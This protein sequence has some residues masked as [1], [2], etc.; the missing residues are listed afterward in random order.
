MDI[1]IR[2]ADLGGVRARVPRLRG[3]GDDHTAPPPQFTL[4]RTPSRRGL[5]GTIFFFPTKAV[6][7]CASPT[8]LDPTP[9]A[10]PVGRPKA[11]PLGSPNPPCQPCVS[12]LIDYQIQ[13]FIAPPFSL[14]SPPSCPGGL[15][16]PGLGLPSPPRGGLILL[17]A[18]S[19]GPAPGRRCEP[20]SAVDLPKWSPR[21]S[22]ALSLMFTVVFWS[23]RSVKRRSRR[24]SGHRGP[25][26]VARSS[27]DVP[28][29]FQ[30]RSPR[31]ARRLSGFSALR[32]PRGVFQAITRGSQ[33]FSGHCGHGGVPLATA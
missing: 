20:R 5:P 15:D 21:C 7:L 32:S 1:F 11:S 14:L 23:S 2:G 29:G 6:A 28:G 19:P 33:W 31:S 25:R 3:G 27:S 22:R 30:I 4:H 13:S 18:P 17:V 16:R 24:F 12:M 10:R 26:G 9:L 8:V